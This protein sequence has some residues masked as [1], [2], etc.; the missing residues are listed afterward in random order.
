MTTEHVRLKETFA[1]AAG[2]LLRFVPIGLWPATVSHL[3]GVLA[4][5]AVVPHPERSSR[6]G[7]NV[8]ILLELL[9]RT[10]ELEGDIAE[11]GVWRGRSLIAMGIYVTQK[12][13]TKTIWGFDSFR[14]FDDSVAQDIALGGEQV[15]V[16]RIHGF[17]DTSYALVNRKATVFG[18]RDM[19]IVPGYFKESLSKCDARKFSFVHIDCD[20]YES[21][22]ECL[23]F[24][25]PRM[26]RGG[27]ILFDEYNDPAWPGANRAVDEFFAAHPEKPQVIVRDNFEKWF[28]VKL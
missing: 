27:V 5:R 23:E 17:D 10:A 14:G 12:N 18:I 2:R 6:G 25:Y 4:P 22:A 1:G 20:L 15:E 3:T 7:A 21:Y 11:C 16:K 9:D 8:N 19:R 28:V 26:C 24:F 13:V